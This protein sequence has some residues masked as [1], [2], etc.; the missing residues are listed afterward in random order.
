MGANAR[1]CVFP[2]VVLLQCLPPFSLDL[3]CT[4]RS[5]RNVCFQVVRLR[6]FQTVLVVE[7]LLLPTFFL[8]STSLV[9]SFAR[10]L[11]HLFIC[12]FLTCVCVWSQVT[13]ACGALVD[14]GEFLS[15]YWLPF[16]SAVTACG[17][18]TKQLI[19]DF[20]QSHLLYIHMHT[21]VCMAVCMR[22]CGLCICFSIANEHL[23]DAL[24]LRSLA[25][26]TAPTTLHRSNNHFMTCLSVSLPQKVL[27]SRY[28]HVCVCVYVVAYTLGVFPCFSF[29]VLFVVFGKLCRR[30]TLQISHLQ[31]FSIWK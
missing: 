7:P 25:C 6:R 3:L 8:M 28:E 17:G 13:T 21:H 15:N 19:F 2:A 29:K 27:S 1:V 14:F 18:S 31:K 4:A 16:A 23:F 20:A 22:V 11:P 26:S 12:F 5:H 9:R 30:R 10:S 24:P